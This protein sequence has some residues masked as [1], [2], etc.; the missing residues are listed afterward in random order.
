MRET[1]D[2]PCFLR[3]ATFPDVVQLEEFDEP[4]LCLQRDRVRN[5]NGFLGDPR[6][7]CYG[8]ANR[9]VDAP[10]GRV[11]DEWEIAVPTAIAHMDDSSGLA[12]RRRADGLPLEKREQVG[13]DRA[14]LSR[15]HTV[16]KALVGFQCA[17]P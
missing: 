2:F 8:I 17:I 15:G 1:R 7:V 10:A 5:H 14:G 16:R 9:S 13:V 11:V 4:A 3:A 12:S 6:D